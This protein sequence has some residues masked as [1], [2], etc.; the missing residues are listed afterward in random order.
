[1]QHRSYWLGL[2]VVIFGAALAWAA[3]AVSV[4]PVPGGSGT[5]DPNPDCT[6]DG[7]YCNWVNVVIPDGSEIDGVQVFVSNDG[8]NFTPCSAA[9][10]GTY[11][12]CGKGVRFLNTKPG[13]APGTGGINVTWRMMNATTHQQWGKLVVNYH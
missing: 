5:N 9:P 1:M 3:Q 4:E 11:M 8:Q 13:T 10:S 6:T 7:V 2:A 12:D